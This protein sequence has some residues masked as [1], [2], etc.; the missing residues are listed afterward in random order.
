MLSHWATETAVSE[1]YYEVHMTRV[2]HT[3]RISIEVRE[4]VSFELGKEIE[5]D[6]FLSCHERG[7]E[8]ILS[9]YEESNLCAPMLYHWATETPLWA[10]SILF[11]AK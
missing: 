6:V 8:K 1:V 9:P 3:A 10:R 11:P 7:T 5:K 4:M 2:L